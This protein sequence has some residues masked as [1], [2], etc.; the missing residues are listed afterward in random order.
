MNKKDVI[1][2]FGSQ[3]NTA[4]A[5]DISRQAVH[6]W[7]ELIPLDEAIEVEALSGG[8]LKVDITRYRKRKGGKDAKSTEDGSSPPAAPGS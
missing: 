8:K 1:K 2:H 5:L 3:S 7:G 4:R 6:K